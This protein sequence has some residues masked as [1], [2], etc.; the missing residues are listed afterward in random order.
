MNQKQ[1]LILILTVVV[2]I[3]IQKRINAQTV[4][5]NWLFEGNLG[6]LTLF[7]N[8]EN[9][10]YTNSTLKSE[11][12]GFAI[13]IYPRVAYFFTTNIAIGATLIYNYQIDKS[14]SYWANNVVSYESTFKGS[15]IGL[16]PFLRY[17]FTKNTK[18]RF[19]G[20]LGM[21]YTT[22]LF[23]KQDQTSFFENGQKIA[24]YS[25]SSMLKSVFGESVIGFNHFFTESVVFNASIGYNYSSMEQN[26]TYNETYF[27]SYIGNPYSSSNSK[28][29]R[30]TNNLVW[31]IGFAIMLKTKKEK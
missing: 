26:T 25:S 13:G 8:K 22:N 9:Y 4:K 5:N 17:Y 14:K 31:N 20:Q 3:G 19:Y 11:G 30:V 2:S 29:T 21:G 16:S 1:K 10:G 7:S 28:N 6:N 15:N 18:N 12:K 24:T 23:S 27:Y